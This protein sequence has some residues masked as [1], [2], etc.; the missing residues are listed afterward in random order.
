MLPTQTN[1]NHPK[2]THWPVPTPSTPLTTPTPFN[3]LPRATLYGGSPFRRKTRDSLTLLTQR[4]G[5]C[6]FNFP[7]MAVFD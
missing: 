2:S 1:P 5:R 6:L 7:D 4:G 3:R